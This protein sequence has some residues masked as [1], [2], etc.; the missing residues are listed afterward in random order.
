MRAYCLPILLLVLPLLVAGCTGGQPRGPAPEPPPYA[1]LV[2]RYNER[3]DVLDRFY[4]RTVVGLTWEDAEGDR[5]HE[6]GEGHLQFKRY[7]ETDIIWKGELRSPARVA[8]DVGK[9]GNIGYWLGCD[10]ERFWWIDVQEE[11]TAYVARHAN[12]G[13]PC[14][15]SAGLP[16]HPIELINLLALSKLNPGLTATRIEPHPEQPTWSLTRETYFG[17]ERLI[18]D[19]ASLE[20]Q[21]VELLD[22]LGEPV[23][24]AELTEYQPVEI[25]GMAPTIWPRLPRRVIIQQTDGRLQVTLTLS[26]P[27][28]ARKDPR[29]LSD[30]AFIFERVARGLG[31][32]RIVELDADCPPQVEAP[33]AT[34]AGAGS[35]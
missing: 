27:F 2:Q 21:R 25:T 3:L 35:P 26:E 12:F 4:C 34:P 28:D 32:R 6:Q 29:K 22:P 24:V 13:Q 18:L 33:S 19:S 17:L 1:E 11:D 20:V 16:L 31:A 7:E 5:H 10:A 15:D 8:L 30:A 23:V 9:I 14:C